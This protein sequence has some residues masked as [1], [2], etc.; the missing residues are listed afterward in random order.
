MS[1]KVTQPATTVTIDGHQAAILHF[2]LTAAIERMTDQ[3]K[4]KGAQPFA[5]A[6]AWQIS[7]YRAEREKLEAAFPRLVDEAKQ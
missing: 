1:A 7:A 4:L 5:D 3:L 2:A 6:I